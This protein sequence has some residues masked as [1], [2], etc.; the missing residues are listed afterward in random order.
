MRIAGQPSAYRAAT[1]SSAS[2][3]SPAERLRKRRRNPPSDDD[4][5]CSSPSTVRANF[6]QQICLFVGQA[7]RHR[8]HRSLSPP[9]A[10]RTARRLFAANAALERKL[11]RD[12]FSLPSEC[13]EPEAMRNA[14]LVISQSQRHTALCCRESRRSCPLLSRLSPRTISEPIRDVERTP[15]RRLASIAA[16]CADRGDVVHLPRPSS[17]SDRFPKSARR[18]GRRR[19]TCR[20]ARSPAM[21]QIAPAIHAPQGLFGAITDAELPRF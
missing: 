13:R 7:V 12:R 9:R 19:C 2:R 6:L 5:C 8:S 15:E 20:I 1:P 21:R 18:R 16:M 4:R 17:C 14:I 10:S 11:P 3:R